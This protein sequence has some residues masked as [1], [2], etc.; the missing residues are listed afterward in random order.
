MVRTTVGLIGLALG[1]A[2]WAQKPK[3]PP[4]GAGTAADKSGARPI[5]RI[6]FAKLLPDAT[7]EV[8]KSPDWMVIDESV[9]VAH[10][11]ENVITRIDPKNNKVIEQVKA[12][13]NPCAGLAA[14]AGSLWVPNCGDQ[15]VTRID[16][17]TGKVTATFPLPVPDSEGGIAFGAGSA[18]AVTDKRGT[19]VRIDPAN[20][21]AVAEIRLPT[22]SFNVNF[23]EGAV[24]ATSTTEN[25]L[26]RIDPATNLIVETIPVGKKPRFFAVGEGAVWVLNQGD[27]SVSKVDVKTNKVAETIQ[28]GTPGQGGDI[29]LGGGSVWITVL[30]TPLTRIDVAT[31]RAVQ[32]FTGEGGDAVRFGLGSVWLTHLKGGKLWRFDPKRIEAT[33]PE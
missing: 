16:L 18:W 22:G 4:A 31:N 23:G 10:Y 19:L 17:K 5:P 24:W 25:V 15:T 3:T 8:P 9:W 21:Q 1:I 32:Q 13:R 33:L 30:G 11:P 7:F 20:N 6:G 26:T 29:A 14:G 2:V 12:G 28:A 27:G